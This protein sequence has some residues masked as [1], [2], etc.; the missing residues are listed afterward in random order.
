MYADGRTRLKDFFRQ[1]RFRGEELP[2]RIRALEK[3]LAEE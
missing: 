1:V 2:E 3:K